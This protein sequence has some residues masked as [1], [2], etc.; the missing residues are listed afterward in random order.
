M[1]KLWEKLARILWRVRRIVHVAHGHGFPQQTCYIRRDENERTITLLIP[2]CEW[3]E[4][5]A[6]NCEI[7]ADIGL[8]RAR[9]NGDHWEVGTISA[10]CRDIKWR[11]QKGEK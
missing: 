11:L 6:R 2:L 1:A 10:L 5:R 4:F 7:Y 9:R 8:V 3:L